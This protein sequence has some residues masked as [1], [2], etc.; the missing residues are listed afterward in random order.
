MTLF[1]RK[2]K[3]MYICELENIFFQNRGEKVWNRLK[4]C[5]VFK[6]NSQNNV[7]LRII[8]SKNLE[9]TGVNH[10]EVKIFENM[11]QRLLYST[12]L[13]QSDQSYF[14]NILLTDEFLYLVQE[15]HEQPLSCVKPQQCQVIFLYLFFTMNCPK[16]MFLSE[17]YFVNSS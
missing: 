1:P 10:Q 14:Q 7:T 15:V 8:F 16:I 2:A 4:D 17:Y 12:N 6:Q 5:S 3:G 11:D 13:L 9:S